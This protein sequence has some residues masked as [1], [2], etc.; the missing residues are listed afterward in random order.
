MPVPVNVRRGSGGASNRLTQLRKMPH[1]WDQAGANLCLGN[2]DPQ[3]ERAGGEK[4]L[5]KIGGAGDDQ[6]VLRA[7]WLRAPRARINKNLEELQTCAKIIASSVSENFEAALPR[8]GWNVKAVFC[9]DGTMSTGGVPLNEGSIY[10]RGSLVGGA[11]SFWEIDP[12]TLR[13][14]D[15][16]Q[17]P[18]SGL[19]AEF[20]RP[21]GAQNQ[22]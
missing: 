9:G 21:P 14:C 11:E 5:L 22:T 8:S 10:G 20:P 4:A 15:M 16:G 3:P 18:W 7:L 13:V 6:D 12:S 1:A 17:T 19:P 2:G